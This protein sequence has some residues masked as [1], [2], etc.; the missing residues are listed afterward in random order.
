MLERTSIELD[1][2]ANRGLTARFWVRDDDASDVS[3]QLYRLSDLARRHGVPIGLA[4]IPARMT[5]ALAQFVKSSNFF[6]MCHGWKHTN[7]GT[8]AKPGEFGPERPLSLRVADA[9]LAYQAFTD[10]FGRTK[11]IFVPPFARA[12]DDLVAALIEIGFAGIS[13]GPSRLETKLTL[14]S[15]MPAFRVSS[16][17][18]L[19]RF[20]AQ[21]DL[22][23]WTQ[24]DP[25]N[26]KLMKSRGRD[27][28]DAALAG[29]LRVR[30]RGFISLQSP[31]GLLLHHLV[32]D[33]TIWQTCD[34]LIGFLRNHKAV[35]F[36]G[37]PGLL[38]GS[39]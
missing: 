10:H 30:R 8:S 22:I 20:D 6:P 23:D 9:R 15:W 3:E 28:I 38:E 18:I 12:T 1:R 31:I 5:Q 11:V 17:T 19:P 26:H 34:E 35:Q 16:G 39:K 21:I 2:W 4:V 36:F 37:V 24:F 27:E 33:Q 29:Y 7:Y 13:N 14:Y 25:D 32:H